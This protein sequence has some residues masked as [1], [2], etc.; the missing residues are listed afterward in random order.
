MDIGREDEVVDVGEGGDGSRMVESIEKNEGVREVE[1]NM[2]DNGGD[3]RRDEGGR[4][5]GI[6]VG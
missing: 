6:G 1:G 3:G 5:G 2:E 4:R